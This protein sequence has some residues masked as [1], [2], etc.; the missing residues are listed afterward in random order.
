MLIRVCVRLKN[1]KKIAH[2]TATQTINKTRRKKKKMG[3]ISD[4][5]FTNKPNA[6]IDLFSLPEHIQEYLCHSLSFDEE[7]WRTKNKEKEEFQ[8]NVDLDELESDL[9]DDVKENDTKLIEKPEKIIT[10]KEFGGFCCGKL[11]AY[12]TGQV[13]KTWNIIAQHVSEPVVLYFYY[14]EGQTFKIELDNDA[15]NPNAKWFINR[16]EFPH[17]QKK[18]KKKTKKRSRKEFEEEAKQKE[19]ETKLGL[20]RHDDIDVVAFYDANEKNT[21]KW[22]PISIEPNNCNFM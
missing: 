2:T 20:E 6:T 8:K 10:M 9:P 18:K 22:E 5:L 1:E 13:K 14:E 12:L 17:H 21:I 4:F 19:K 11:Y 16:V 15:E 3:M 7:L